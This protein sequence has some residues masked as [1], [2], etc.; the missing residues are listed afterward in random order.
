VRGALVAAG[1]AVGAG[2]HEKWTARDGYPLVVG[3]VERRERPEAFRQQS[4]EL[5]AC[6]IVSVW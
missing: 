4:S 5:I 1:E 6:S 3:A 2:A